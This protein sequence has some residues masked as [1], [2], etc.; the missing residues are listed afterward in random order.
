MQL[1]LYNW[2]Y[3]QIPSVISLKNP[4]CGGADPTT[5]LVTRNTNPRNRYCSR[6]GFWIASVLVATSV[7][8]WI[9]LWRR[10]VP[11]WQWLQWLPPLW[12]Y[13]MLLQQIHYWSHAVMAERIFELKHGRTTATFPGLTVTAQHFHTVYQHS[14]D[15]A[16][17]EMQCLKKKSLKD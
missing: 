8:N 11:V 12:L 7:V 13:R 16:I 1:I 4:K 10:Y 2:I 15:R 5:H 14:W 3:Q 6:E 17:L 9:E